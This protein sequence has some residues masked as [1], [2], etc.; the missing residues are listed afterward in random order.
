MA[1]AAA[2]Y[3]I[4]VLGQVSCFLFLVLERKAHPLPEELSGQ[5]VLRTLAEQ[6]PF[7]TLCGLNLFEQNLPT[8]A[9][10]NDA[11]VA[12]L[13]ILPRCGF[14]RPN[15]HWTRTRNAQCGFGRKVL[16]GK[17]CLATETSELPQEL[18]TQVLTAERGKPLHQDGLKYKDQSVYVYSILWPF[19]QGGFGVCFSPSHNCCSV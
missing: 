14:V 1:M 17:L 15:S 6:H 12:F 3:L 13:S 8:N 9:C 2:K 7:M 19:K 4:L 18:Q 10:V 11:F 5:A 16:S